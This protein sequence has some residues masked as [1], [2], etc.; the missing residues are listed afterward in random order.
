[1][2]MGADSRPKHVRLIER[3]GAPV[4][5]R[6]PFTYDRW[7]KETGDKGQYPESP[8]SLRGVFTRWSERAVNPEYEKARALQ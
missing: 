3:F 1:M 2:L 8:D 4:S 5:G 7:I 6:R